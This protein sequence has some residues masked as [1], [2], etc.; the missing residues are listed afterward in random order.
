MTLKTF[1]ISVFIL[2][3]MQA[4]LIIAEHAG[5]VGTAL[6]ICPAG[7]LAGLALS[8]MDLP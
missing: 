2:A 7:I 8:Q 1:A 4:G 3:A 5:V 6:T